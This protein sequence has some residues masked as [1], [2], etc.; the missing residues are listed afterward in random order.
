MF[1]CLQSF[2]FS[3]RYTEVKMECWIYIFIHTF[4]CWF[5][6]PKEWIDGS[7]CKY[8]YQVRLINLWATI[9]W[10]HLQTFLLFLRF[11]LSTFTMKFSS[12]LW[13]YFTSSSFW[14]SAYCKTVRSQN[15]SCFVPV[16]FVSVTTMKSTWVIVHLSTD[17][18]N[19]FCFYFVYSMI[20][21]LGGDSSRWDRCRG[22]KMKHNGSFFYHFFDLLNP[23]NFFASYSL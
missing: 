18:T 14:N 21:L 15:C 9:H 17:Y 7:R 1:S 16:F 6:P 10:I 3:S 5:S 8:I 13:L 22:K 11:F 23:Y 4:N 12:L 2:L 20:S 19:Y